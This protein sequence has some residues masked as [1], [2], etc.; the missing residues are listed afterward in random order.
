MKFLPGTVPHRARS[1]L[2]LV[3]ILAAIPT[4]IFLIYGETYAQTDSSEG[5]AAPSLTAE[6]S[7]GQVA[8]SWN[9]VTEAD[10]YELIFWDSD[11]SDWV[12]IG[13]DLKGTNYTHSGLAGGTTYYYSIRVVTADGAVGPWVATVSVAVPERVSETETLTLTATLSPVETSTATSTLTPT[14]TSIVTSTA[15]ATSTPTLTV[16]V[17]STATSTS[18]PTL[19]VAVTSTATST[20]TSTSTPT[21]TPDPVDVER[22]AL[23]ALYNATGG[24]SWTGRANW[25]SDRPVSEWHGITT[26]ENGRVTELRLST[27]NLSGTVPDLSA[28]KQLLTLDLGANGLTGPFPD[29]SALTNLGALDLTSNDISGSIPDMGVLTKLQRLYL[30]N[31]SLTGTIPASLG[32]IPILGSLFLGGNSLSGCIP[33][34]LRDVEENDLDSLGLPYCDEATATPTFTPTPAPVAT[35]TPNWHAYCY[36]NS[37]EHAYRH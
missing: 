22:A 32:D 27:N 25:L 9:E 2:L 3:A 16:I 23:I 12:R 30:G 15:T 24:D 29:V 31:N 21:L 34:T 33:E 13:G 36:P 4:F 28:L 37:I 1:P 26:D 20:A 18:T 8:L 10:S 6:A 19:T 35:D 14:L 11:A 7:E 17:T 5:L